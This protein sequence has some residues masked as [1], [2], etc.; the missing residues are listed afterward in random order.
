M[1]VGVLDYT[2]VDRGEGMIQFQCDHLDAQGNLVKSRLTFTKN[3]DGT[4]RQLFEGS[5][6]GEHWTTG[7]DG[8]YKPKGTE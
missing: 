8:L 5:P 3:A 4:V 1:A 6:D 7:F 2:E